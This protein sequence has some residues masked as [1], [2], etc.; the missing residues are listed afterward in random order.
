MM[1]AIP[2]FTQSPA[3]IKSQHSN[4]TGR[5][6]LGA[7]V[8]VVDPSNAVIRKAKV[9][10]LHVWHRHSCLCECVPLGE[11]AHRQECRCHTGQEGEDPGIIA[12]TDLRGVVRYSG[13]AKGTYKIIVEAPGFTTVQ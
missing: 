10:L 8:T 1:A 11:G 3:P 2:V 9:T 12:T 4:A 7:D 5:K 13:L 6:Q